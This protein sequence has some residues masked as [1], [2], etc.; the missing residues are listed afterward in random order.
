MYVY[1]V[2]NY[3]SP[4]LPSRTGVVYSSLLFY[5][6]L[7]FCFSS[8]YSLFSYIT[9]PLLTNYVLH[10]LLPRVNI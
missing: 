8:L 4:L 1:T 3:V 9:F 6:S 2:R 5:S 7:K 10:R